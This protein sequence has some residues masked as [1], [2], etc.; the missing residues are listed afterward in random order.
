V[1]LSDDMNDLLGRMT[2]LLMAQGQDILLKPFR[3]ALALELSKGAHTILKRR[4]KA[5]LSQ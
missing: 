4:A 2:G 1:K 3:S 5:S